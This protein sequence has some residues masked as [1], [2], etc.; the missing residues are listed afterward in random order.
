MTPQEIRDAIAASPELQ[1][2]AA[3]RDD[4]AIAAALSLG[5]TKA[6]PVTKFT[7]L[8]IAEKFPAL[9]PLPGPLAA[10]MV[11]QKIEGFAAFAVQQADP[12]TKLLGAATQR[13]MKHLE[14][15]G[16]AIGSPAIGAM[17]M[18]MV[19]A[20]ALTQQEVDALV[21]VAAVE[22]PVSQHEVRVAIFAD[23]GTLLV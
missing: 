17:L 4:Q 10:E 9:G 13:Q 1:A 7:S 12:A 20:G 8:G 23:D 21:S 5:R 15:N 3:A 2:L 6:D 22:D 14:G 18:V 19:Q 16:M 11:L